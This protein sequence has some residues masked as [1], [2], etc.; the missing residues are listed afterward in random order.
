MSDRVARTYEGVVGVLAVRIDFFA[1][2]NGRWRLFITAVLAG[3][4][5]HVAVLARNALFVGRR[6]AILI[7]N[8]L[9]LDSRN[10]R[11]L[12]A[13]YAKFGRGNVLEFYGRRMDRNPYLLLIGRYFVVVLV[14]DNLSDSARIASAIHRLGGQF[15]RNNAP[16]G[17]HFPVFFVHA[18][19]RNAGYAFAGD[20][21]PLP[22]RL[23][24]RFAHSGTDS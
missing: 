16:F 7:P 11:N 14:F 4:C 8:R 13:G 19:A 5:A 9:E 21:V 3:D 2:H 17:V 24:A 6:G 12:M 18:V 10:D 15:A 20:L 1:V 22:C 23:L